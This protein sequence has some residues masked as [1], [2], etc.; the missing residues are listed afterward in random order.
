MTR[1]HPPSSRGPLGLL[2]RAVAAACLAW[3]GTGGLGMA[4]AQTTPPTALPPV[5]PP[6][7]TVTQVLSQ[8]PQV[9]AASAGLPLAQARSQRLEA[10]PHDWIAKA[11]ANRRTERQGP[12]FSEAEVALDELYTQGYLDFAF[13]RTLSRLREM[14]LERFGAS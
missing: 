7:E 6:T 12:S 5:L 13:R 9:R 2:R 10:G 4:M 8:L 11:G 14:Q 3:A 1:L